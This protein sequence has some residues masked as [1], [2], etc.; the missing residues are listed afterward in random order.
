MLDDFGPL[1]PVLPGLA[2]HRR[3]NA[4][5]AEGRRAYGEAVLAAIRAL[6]RKEI[7]GTA[8]ALP[9][10]IT[11]GEQVLAA[12]RRRQLAALNAPRPPRDPARCA[13]S[14]WRP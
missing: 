3:A 9:P 6:Q 4:Q 7:M 12:V 8:P 2:R 14:M 13:R 1:Y 5:D 11:S 10:R